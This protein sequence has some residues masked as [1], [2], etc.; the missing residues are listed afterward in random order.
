[1]EL[2]A[3][4]TGTLGRLACVG[5]GSILP[6]VVLLKACCQAFMWDWGT[7]KA[8]IW[9]LVPAN[10]TIPS[11]LDIYLGRNKVFFFPSVV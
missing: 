8:L 7:P 11:H 1:M 9:S 4:A 10:H 2:R 5:K 6:S 3:E